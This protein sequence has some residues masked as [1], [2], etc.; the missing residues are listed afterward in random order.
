MEPMS[1]SRRKRSPWLG[2][3]AEDRTT[4][5]K[6]ATGESGGNRTV[7]VFRR[8]RCPACGG[9]NVLVQRTEGD[10][11]RMLCEDCGI[12]FKSVWV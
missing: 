7:I 10:M 6:P 12:T 5:L 1:W 2:S 9:A 3:V 8:L 4:I 11:R